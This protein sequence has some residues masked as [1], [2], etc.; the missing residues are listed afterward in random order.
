MQCEWPEGYQLANVMNF[1][2]PQFSP[3]PLES[4]VSNCHPDG[5]AMLNDMLQWNQ[6]RRPTA[7]Q[8]LKYNYFKV[9]QKLGPQQINNLTA[10]TT[11]NQNYSDKTA[12]NPIESDNNINGRLKNIYNGSPN[13]DNNSIQ[14]LQQQIGT[15]ASRTSTNSLLKSGLSV[16]D[17]YLAR[18]RY[19][20]GQNTK[21]ASYRNSGESR[22]G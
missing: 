2:F 15:H 12:P 19:I 6:S 21:N 5:I 18:S 20:A 11:L 22:F 14:Q 7:L 3:M 1:R 4:I 16:K 17:Q 9:S 10:K 13:V 8:S